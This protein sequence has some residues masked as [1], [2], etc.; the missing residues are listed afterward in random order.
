MEDEADRTDSHLAPACWVST[1]SCSYFKV[2]GRQSW[3]ER[4]KGRSER[5]F[6]LAAAPLYECYCVSSTY[7][8]LLFAS[9]PPAATAL[10][11][12][13][14]DFQV[15]DYSG[16]QVCHECLKSCVC[17]VVHT[18][19][20]RFTPGSAILIT[21]RYIYLR[22]FFVSVGSVLESWL[23]RHCRAEC[24]LNPW[25]FFNR[26]S[27]PAAGGSRCKEEA[28]FERLER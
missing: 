28:L 2:A 13:G 24:F 7:S 18:L 5:C 6:C 15:M 17:A 20:R 14:P 11:S 23:Q 26:P 22:C 19:I 9:V 10:Q 4:R 8:S 21:P 25:D 16:M 12:S 27:G 3:H 1:F